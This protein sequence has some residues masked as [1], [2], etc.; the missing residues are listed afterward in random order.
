M[1]INTRPPGIQSVDRDVAAGAVA[2]MVENRVDAPHA[3]LGTAANAHGAGEVPAVPARDRH[4][5]WVT[6]GQYLFAAIVT[7]AVL[8]RLMHLSQADWHIPLSY[9]GDALMF[10]TECDAVVKTGWHLHN[11]KL[12][13]PT[14]AGWRTF[15]SRTTCTS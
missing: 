14:R 4:A 11:P 13:A 2:G 7:V 5:I 1:S 10:Q 6:A 12:G 15:R 8:S 3:S 9:G